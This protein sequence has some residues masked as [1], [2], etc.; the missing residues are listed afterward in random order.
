VV[1]YSRLVHND[2]EVT[3]AKLTAL[4]M[5]VV[6]LAIAER[7]GRIVKNTGTGSWPSFRVRSRRFGL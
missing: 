6:G 2:E 7:G 1:Y 5:D 4:L 3:H